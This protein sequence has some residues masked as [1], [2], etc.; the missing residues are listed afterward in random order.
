MKY[1]VLLWGATSSTGRL[2]AEYLAVRYGVGRS[3]SW[4][5][6]GRSREKV[7]KIREGLKALDPRAGEIPL[8]IGDARDTAFLDGAV[9]SARV[10]AS[11]VGPYAK[12]GRELVAACAKHGTHYCDLTG[13]VPFMRDMIDAHDEEAKRTGAKI[14][15]A[16][17]F[18]SIPSDLGVLLLQDFA[19]KKTG[20]R[21]SRVKLFVTGM[22]GGLGGGTAATMIHMF[23][24]M[25][26]PRVRAILSDPYSLA[27]GTKGAD[28][29]DSVKAK[30]D[31]DL[32][33][34]TGP[35]V[36]APT[37]SR[38]VRRTNALLGGKYGADFRYGESVAC[39]SKLRAKALSAGMLS[40]MGALT[41]APARWLI[42]KTLLPAP[43]QGPSE[44]VRK[45]GY[46]TLRLIGLGEGGA[47]IEGAVGDSLDPGHG[48]TAKMMGESAVCLALDKLEGGGGVLTPASAMGA[49]L[50][51]RLRGAGMTFTAG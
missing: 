44:K 48:S 35:W 18:D 41:I 19:Q 46:F 33:G 29:G 42:E 22:R 40:F 34:W 23:E 21:L 20:A 3:L 16:C 25:K 32:A 9:P 50:V 12:Y 6:G 37:N 51:E 45:S 47:R 5:L 2:V 39:K 36:M 43:G 38:V 17:G 11:T 31:D 4:A 14:V 7:E 10:V 26:D 15:H 27:P 49:K 1:D 30:W 24:E 28:R 13:E 8:V